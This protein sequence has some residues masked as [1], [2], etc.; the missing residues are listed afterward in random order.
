MNQ[1]RIEHAVF[2]LNTSNLQIQMIA[3]YSGIAD[4]NYF[5]KTF[6]KIIGI[7]PKEYRD[8]ISN[9]F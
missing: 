3:Q 1:K 6:K 2:L 4:V 5:T 7:T 8:N 9:P